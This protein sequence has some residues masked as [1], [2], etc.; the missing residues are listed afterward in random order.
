MAA[1]FEWDKVVR[2]NPATLEEECEEDYLK[3]VFNM[4]V[5]VIVHTHSTLV[6][7]IDSASTH[8]Y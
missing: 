1:A 8:W 4:L 3:K 2:I 5:L 6:L 7:I